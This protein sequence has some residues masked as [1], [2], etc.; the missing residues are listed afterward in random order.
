[1]SSIAVKIHFTIEKKNLG[2]GKNAA[3]FGAISG[4]KGTNKHLSLTCHKTDTIQQ[5]IIWIINFS[6]QIKL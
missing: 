4:K 6:F 3:F 1:M 2:G 5:N